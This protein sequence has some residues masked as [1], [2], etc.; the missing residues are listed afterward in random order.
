MAEDVA[1][2]VLRCPGA[3]EEVW[4]SEFT[5]PGPPS[6]AAHL[7]ATCGPSLLPLL[8]SPRPPT[9]VR[10]RKPHVALG[11][12]LAYSGVEITRRSEPGGG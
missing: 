6:P 7:E 4:V 11:G 12:R 8:T 2:A 5:Y 3:G 1:S 9:K 10:V